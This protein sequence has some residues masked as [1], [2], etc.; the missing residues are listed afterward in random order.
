MADQ[1]VQEQPAG[2]D[3]AAGVFDSSQ[4]KSKL[5]KII[6]LIAFSKL[7]ELVLS[8]MAISMLA[9]CCYRDWRVARNDQYESVPT[10]EHFW[11]VFFYRSLGLLCRGA[12]C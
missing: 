7:L 9:V 1:I 2:K 4:R 11:L 3:E 10:F 5:K 6:R 8:I 12:E